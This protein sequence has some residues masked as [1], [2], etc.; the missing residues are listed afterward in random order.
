MLSEAVRE[1]IRLR[2][3]SY[4]IEKHYLHWILRFVRF[5]GRRHPKQMGEQEI[6]VIPSLAVSHMPTNSKLTEA[7]LAAA[8]SV[9][10]DAA[11][12][13]AVQEIAKREPVMRYGVI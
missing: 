6:Y 9:V 1:A 3:L 11:Y 8:R 2:H 13:F 4:K 12:R 5:H 7:A 10:D